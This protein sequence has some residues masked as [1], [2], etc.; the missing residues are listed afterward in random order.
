[1]HLSSAYYRSSHNK[2]I[3]D[4][5]HVVRFLT[6]NTKERPSTEQ[7]L[8]VWDMWNEAH[9]SRSDFTESEGRDR[10]AG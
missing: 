10:H 4:D 5:S 3:F 7:F 2:A 8:L 1:V 9:H 6:T